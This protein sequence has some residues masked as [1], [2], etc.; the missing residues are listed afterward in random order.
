ML[1]LILLL[2]VLW[3]LAYFRVSF[4]ASASAVAAVLL[5]MSAVTGLTLPVVLLWAVYLVVV[6]PLGVPSLRQNLM[7]A[8]LLNFMRGALPPI[9]QTEREAL[10]AG[11]VW[12]DAELFSGKPEW[13]RLLETPAPR[14]SEKEQAFID[15]PVEELCAML[16][17]WRITHDIQDLPE[18]VWAFLKSNRFFGMIIPEQYGGLEFSALA[19]SEVVMKVASRSL[20]AAV[21]VMVPNSL[22]PAQ[23]LLEY[24]TEEQKQHYLP[25]LAV[26]EEIPCFALT[27]PEAGSDAGAIPDTG[28]VCKGEYKGEQDVIGIR[29]NWDKRYITL[30]P[31]ATVLGL[32]FKLYD[33][34]HLLGE[35]EDLG[36]TLA[37][38]P[39]DLEG[40][41]VG[42]RHLPLDSAFQNGP[43][44][45]KDVFI[46]LDLIIGGVDQAGKGWRMLMECLAEGRGIS[47]P[48][49]AT[50]AGKVMSRVTGAYSR[51][52]TQFKMPIGKFEGIEEPLARIA[53]N[54]Y[55]MDAARKLT[56]TAVD[57]GQ[58]PSVISAIVKYQLTER[59]RAAVNDAMDIQGGSGICLGPSNFIGRLYEA[60]PIGITVEGANILTRSMIIFGQGAIRCHP[61]LL[62]EVNAAQMEQREEALERFDDALFKHV[63]YLTSNLARSFW[64]GLT[65]AVF[66]RTPGDKETR[67]YYRQLTRLSA[68]FALVSDTALLSL[69][70]LLKRKERLSGYFADILSNLYLASAVLKH[71]EDQGRQ[72]ADLPLLHYACRSTIYRAQQAM[73]AV[74]W[75]LPLRPIAYV[76]RALA[77]PL[78]K[79]Y[80]P[81]DDNMIHEVAQLLLEPSAVRERL[82]QGI[83][84]TQEQSDAAG[85]I[86]FAFERVSTAAGAEHK[87][88]KA[89][90]EG[91]VKSNGAG[92]DL[93]AA[94]ESG[95][96]NTE[97]AEQLKAAKLATLEA[98]RVDE[99]G[100]DEFTARK[101]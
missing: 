84:K 10:E 75:N 67:R 27:G 40:V 8:R 9:S 3:A 26:G 77:F 83:Y 56:A 2:A 89:L 93:D 5:V 87:L 24:G 78:G 39:T 34:D 6:I 86:E 42:N 37:L 19:H 45:G 47:L 17:D 98:I 29:L 28:I 60:L 35:Q 95:V 73:F 97:E 79:P 96:I 94:V 31:V 76:L 51:V 61:H 55:I 21:T 81:A 44:R 1:W 92:P 90:R 50:G 16:D 4:L 74:F 43:T 64:L 85:R 7:S 52:R 99:F 33:P 48:A 63:G 18:E 62:D 71:Y 80:R 38:I 65:N 25:R 69:G 32:A 70:G 13:K 82:T 57:I 30:A 100:P 22:G 36:I 59:M 66:T 54:A 72:A 88:K 46:P 11:S 12:W 58:K 14:F 68:A 20:T 15:G 41:S 49:L 53:G 101:H 91:T 23:L